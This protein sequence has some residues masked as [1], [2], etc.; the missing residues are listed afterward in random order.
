MS[1]ITVK[2]NKHTFLDMSVGWFV[3]INGVKS[4]GEIT[5]ESKAIETAKGLVKEL[6]GQFEEGIENTNEMF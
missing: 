1:A 2:V 6:K 5:S 4:G 3:K